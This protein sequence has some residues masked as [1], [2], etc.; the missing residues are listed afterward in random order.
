M[1]TY[2]DWWN[3]PVYATDRLAE[4]K[5]LTGRARTSIQQLV[6]FV[7]S[8]ADRATVAET[9]RRRYGS[10]NSNLVT[11]TTQELVDHFSGLCQLGVERFYV[12][13]TDF[14]AY[15]T[16]ERFGEVIAALDGGGA[17]RPDG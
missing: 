12:W 5:P 17:G 7:P 6:A 14:A 10:W 1:A 3:V 4:L 16:L 9:A 2:A 11:G 13:F 15:P 8:E